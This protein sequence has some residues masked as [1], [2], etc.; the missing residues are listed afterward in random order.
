MGNNEADWR[1]FEPTHLEINSPL[2]DYQLLED[3]LDLSEIEEMDFSIEIFKFPNTSTSWTGD[4][5]LD[6]EEAPFRQ[7][8]T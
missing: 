7:C 1:F 6:A 5:F 4:M 2:G 3:I 8:T